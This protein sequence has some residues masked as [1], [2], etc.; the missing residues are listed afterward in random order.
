[1]LGTSPWIQVSSYTLTVLEAT[2]FDEIP[3]N[4]DHDKRKA[5]NHNKNISGQGQ[6]CLQTQTPA[7]DLGSAP[8]HF[9]TNPCLSCGNFCCL[10]AV[11]LVATHGH[12]TVH[13]DLSHEATQRPLLTSVDVSQTLDLEAAW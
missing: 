10:L 2:E 8:T 3:E 7:P 11:L 4:K 13:R 6:D 5:S 9:S 12:L 1:M